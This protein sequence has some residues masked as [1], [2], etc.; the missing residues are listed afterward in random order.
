MKAEHAAAIVVFVPLIVVACVNS[1]VPRGGEH[2]GGRPQEL[3][4]VKKPK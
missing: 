3:S 2:H 1:C 4:W